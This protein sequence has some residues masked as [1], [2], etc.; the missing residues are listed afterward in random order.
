MQKCFEF[1]LNLNAKY[2]IKKQILKNNIN[3]NK[4]HNL[5]NI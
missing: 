2:I 5:F 1:F 4:L 3:K